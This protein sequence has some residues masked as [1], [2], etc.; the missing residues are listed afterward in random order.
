MNYKDGKPEELKHKFW[1]AL[2]DSPYV[3]LQLDSD[4]HTAVPM[5]AQLDKDADSAIWFFT[6]R[7][8]TFAQGGPATATFA[9]KGHDIF[10]RFNGTLREE[11]SRERLNEEWSNFVEAYFPGGKDDPNLLMLRMDLGTAE[12]WNSDLGML[13]TARMMLGKDV[14]AEARKENTK[15]TL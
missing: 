14:R 1:K 9:G 6:S 12:L 13:T 8:H 10:A 2:A 4:P 11:L 7:D 15:T 3:F 5:T